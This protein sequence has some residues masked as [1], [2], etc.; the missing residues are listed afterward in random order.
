MPFYL[1][2][3]IKQ[4]EAN[5]GRYYWLSGTHLNVLDARLGTVVSSI[6][7]KASKF[8]FDSKLGVV[9]FDEATREINFFDGDLNLVERVYVENLVGSWACDSALFLNQADEPFVFKKSLKKVCFY[10]K[11]IEYNQ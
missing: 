5:S 1:P 9:L 10:R 7:V 2:E 8:L 3:T 4:F 11:V 6:E